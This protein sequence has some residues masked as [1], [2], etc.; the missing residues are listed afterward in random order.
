PARSVSTSA[1]WCSATSSAGSP[2]SPT[3][4]RR[5]RR[6]SRRNPSGPSSP[7]DLRHVF[8]QPARDDADEEEAELGILVVELACLLRRDE[9]ERAGLDAGCRRSAHAINRKNTDLAEQAALA[10]LDIEL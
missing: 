5:R 6:S 2:T 7:R 4:Q 10:D 1:R 8:G 9:K 3:L